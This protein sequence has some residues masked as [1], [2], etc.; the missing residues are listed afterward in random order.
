MCAA[1]SVSRRSVWRV[2]A[3]CDLHDEVACN[4]VPRHPRPRMMRVRALWES[5]ASTGEDGQ[6]PGEQ[7]APEQPPLLAAQAAPRG[8]REDGKAERQ[9]QGRQTTGSARLHACVRAAHPH[10][11]QALTPAGSWLAQAGARVWVRIMRGGLFTKADDRVV[12]EP[13]VS[14]MLQRRTE[15]KARKDFDA[16]DKIA[17]QLQGMGI[18]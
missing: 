16:A 4:V 18:W 10:A 3:R 11:G 1:P 15:C 5:P 8:T 2:K 17:S 6:E 7:P 9:G 13:A 12:D 14:A